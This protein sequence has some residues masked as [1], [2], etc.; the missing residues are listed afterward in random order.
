VV[1]Q[2]VEQGPGH[3]VP[4]PSRMVGWF[5]KPQFRAEHERPGFLTARNHVRRRLGLALVDEPMVQLHGA[6][7]ISEATGLSI[8][9]APTNSSGA[10]K[11]AE[12][13]LMQLACF[14]QPKTQASPPT[15]AALTI[16]T[17]KKIGNRSAFSRNETRKGTVLSQ[18]GG[19]TQ[20]KRLW[21]WR[22]PDA[23]NWR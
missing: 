13:A 12:M 11:K 10:S 21:S 14:S 8:S 6:Q 9:P 2:L 23:R 15:G 3:R 19:T 18:P 4:F 7:R 22:S 17:T 20:R 1:H 5:L 16:E